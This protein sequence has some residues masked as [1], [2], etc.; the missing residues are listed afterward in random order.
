FESTA[1]VA[2]LV[3]TVHE[4]VRSLPDVEAAAASCCV[5]LQN[6]ANMPF[7]I[8]GREAQAPF[9]GVA[10]FAPV[11]AGYF[12]TLGIRVLAGRAFD[13][14]D[15]A[16][17]APVAIIDQV[18]AER[19]FAAG[20]NPLDGRL[21]AGGGAE[22]IPETAGEPPRH[23]VG[24]VGSV[25][26]E[27]TYRE[28]QP[29][30][31]IPLSQ[32]SDALNALIVESGPSAW[33]VRTRSPSAAAA[34][35][36]R[37]EISRATGAPTTGVVAM[38]EV[39]AT[40]TAPYRLK[41]WLM[42]VFGGVALLLTAVAIYGVISYAVEQRRREIGIRMALGAEASDV[43]AMVVRDGMLPVVAGIGAGLVAAYS[44]SKVL[45]ATL[46]GVQPRDLGV[47]ATVPLALTA[48][49]LA[50]ATVPAFRASRVAPTVALRQE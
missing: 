34:A 47:F 39:L 49:G 23:I 28:P 37:E 21:V 22:V 45:A 7:D 8:V 4:R 50:A 46:Y 42:S 3:D 40:T 17:A 18:L 16:G 1:S 43:R 30:L 5:P 38:A 33:L 12:E 14:R 41:A 32:T 31:Y 25:W 20:V 26:S 19:Y 48:V 13:E 29:T 24:I 2:G 6:S 15:D 36:I 35:T 10:V 27:G 11:S 9:T 44:L